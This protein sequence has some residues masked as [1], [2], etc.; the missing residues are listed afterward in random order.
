MDLGEWLRRNNGETIYISN[1]SKYLMDFLV[2]LTT[3]L[4]RMLTEADTKSPEFFCSN[5][6]D[7]FLGLETAIET[8]IE[9][10]CV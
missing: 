7:K 1:P 2:G 5:H 4:G 9:R 3:E 6:F 8:A 10:T